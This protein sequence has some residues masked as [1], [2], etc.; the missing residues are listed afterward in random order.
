[1][2]TISMIQEIF[3]A[4]FFSQPQINME[5]IDEEL[6]V[7]A[8]GGFIDVLGEDIKVKH[9]KLAYK[10]VKF[11]RSLFQSL[12]DSYFCV[13]YAINYLMESGKMVEVRYIVP[14]L[15]KAIQE[16]FY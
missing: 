8:E 6:V 2:K 13:L 1:M 16:I 11:M 10:K 7:M 4:E 15:H 5:T 9:N 14:D 3:S 12:I